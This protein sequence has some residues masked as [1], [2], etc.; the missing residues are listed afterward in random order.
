MLLTAAKVLGSFY[1]VI[2]FVLFLVA[3]YSE[4]SY[5]EEEIQMPFPPMEA[6][7]IILLWLPGAIL[8]LKTRQE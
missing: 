6:L 1:L 2:G 5:P 4:K 3:F 7:V 8:H